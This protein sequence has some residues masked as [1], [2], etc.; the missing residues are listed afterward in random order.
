M[1]SSGNL[2]GTTDMGGNANN[3]QY[4]FGFGTVF[5]L[6]PSSGSQ[7]TESVLHNFQLGSDGGFPQAGLLLDGSGHLFGATAGSAS[8]SVV[9]EII[10]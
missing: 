2:Y 9:Y 6:S 4:E 3:S 8:G 1:D 10:P 7:W 5:E